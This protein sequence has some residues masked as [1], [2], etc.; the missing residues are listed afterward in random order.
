M[1]DDALDDD[2]L[3]EPQ[4]LLCPITRAVFRDPVFVPSSGNTYER[5][6]IEEFWRRSAS[7]GPPRD[8][9]TNEPVV[10][11]H[12]YTNWDKR[13]EV[14][15]WLAEH[16]GRTPSGWDDATQPPPAKERDGPASGGGAGGFFRGAR[17]GL[18]AS[19]AVKAAAVAVMLAVAFAAGPS[20]VGWR[21]PGAKGGAGGSPRMPPI[22]EFGVV[23]DVKVPAGSR[24][25]VRRV[26][27]GSTPAL[28][29]AIPSQSFSTASLLFSI[30]WFAITGT[31]TYGA[32]N[33]ANPIFATFSL[34][35]WAVGFNMIHQSATS[36]FENT[37]LLITTDRFYLEKTIFDRRMFWLKGNTVDLSKAAVETYAY[38]NGVPQQNLVLHHGIKSHVLARGLHAAEDD[39]IVDEIGRF[40]QR[41]RGKKSAPTHDE[42]KIDT[43]T[44][45]FA[46]ARM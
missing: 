12:V 9:L 10:S 41:H 35:F 18:N 42:V 4:R 22:D 28:E 13:R 39:F 2:A 24:I 32:W 11:A 38:V 14:A 21:A 19:T 36:A 27:K 15:D 16:P 17:G 3:D 7:R 30:P 40:L 20:V 1:P 31:W 46:R 34:P 44:P 6:A 45:Y 37:R 33:A 23:S 8:P 26:Q 5:E 43:T 25:R 29:I